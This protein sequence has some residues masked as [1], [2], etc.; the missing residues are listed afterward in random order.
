MYMKHHLKSFY[1]YHIRGQWAFQK[2]KKRLASDQK[3][4]VI[5]GMG[6][7]GSLS[8][9]HSIKAQT[10]IPTFHVHSLNKER[11]DW[12]Y[13]TCRKKGWWPDS[14]NP[15]DL[16]YRHKIQ[17]SAPVS[18]I[19]TIREPIERN[20]SAFFE[21]FRYYNNINA[22]DYKGD[23]TFLQA[24]FLK[25][26]P[27]DYPLTWLDDELK[28]MLNINVFNS[29]FEVQKK[30]QIYQKENIDLLLMRVDLSDTE[31]E[32]Q[33]QELLG[34]SKL[35]LERH[36]IGNQKDYAKL[37]K[38]FKSQLELPQSYVEKM[39]TSKYCKHF[40]SMEERQK[41]FEKWTN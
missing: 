6:K 8:L 2:A 12:E 18:I 11:I 21:V 23:A 31:K 35:K 9:Y 16:I 7:V 22:S 41:I 29:P 32:Q 24:Q 37:Y 3:P 26:V 17:Q 4:V 14:K 20:I 28:K 5:Y 33:V 39:L 13:E 19:T 36:N 34:V 30:Y 27:H 38:T 25:L 1:R 15:G 40:Y 10:S